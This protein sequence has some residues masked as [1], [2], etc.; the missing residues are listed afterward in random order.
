MKNITVV[1]AGVMGCIYGGP[2]SEKYNVTLV[3]VYKPHIDAINKDGLELSD[4]DG[5]LHIYKN[6][7]AT[8]DTTLCS[9]A[10]LV[11]LLCK[12]YQTAD[13]LA[14][15]KTLIG[16]NTIV[17]SLQNGY[18]NADEI[19]KFV[20]EEQ[21]V[22]G[23]SSH[24]GIM[25]GPGKVFHAG[26]GLTQ[27]GCLTKDQ[28]SAERVKEAFE[29]AGIEEIVL[30]PNVKRLVWH[31]LFV[32]CAINPVAG[33]ID[34]TNSTVSENHFSKKAAHA[35]V[36]EA[37]RIANATGM[38]FDFEE[39]FEYVMTV[40]R[41]TA[42]VRCSMLADV[43]NKRKTEVDRMNGAIVNEAKKVGLEAPIN[44]LMT[45]LIHAKELLY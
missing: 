30:V 6:T 26:T 32:N 19:V 37:V 13:A 36:S 8:D 33:L 42:Q 21:I 25:N 3:D 16:P 44:E 20:P 2:L 41:E 38:D 14:K 11:I 9:A 27:L 24:G 35:I 1:G 31:K 7:V 17:L 45:N 4:P 18:G 23:T 39:E 10:D 15:N 22:L 29:N 12:G 28:T 5:T 40:S 43:T 34:D